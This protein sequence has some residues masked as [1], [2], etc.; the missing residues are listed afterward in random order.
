MGMA[1]GRG[2]C[3]AAITRAHCQTNQNHR[4][5]RP[6]G[7]AQHPDLPVA[8]DGEYPQVVRCLVTPG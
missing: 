8:W 7:P 6:R 4:A 3:G 2:E 5:R 1:G